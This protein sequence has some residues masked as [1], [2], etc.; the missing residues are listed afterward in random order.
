M[1]KI[2]EGKF[3]KRRIDRKVFLYISTKLTD[4][5]AWNFGDNDCVT[6]EIVN[7][8]LIVRKKKGGE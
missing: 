8:G 6:V 7:D 5:S 4:D 3:Y 1:G 2:G